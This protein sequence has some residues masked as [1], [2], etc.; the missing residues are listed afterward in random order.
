M[1]GGGMIEHTCGCGVAYR[2][3][4]LAIEFDVVACGCEAVPAANEHHFWE[5]VL[6][7]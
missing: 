1:R 4:P 5:P 6:L 3:E 7:S 2:V